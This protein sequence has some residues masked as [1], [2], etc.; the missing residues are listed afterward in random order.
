M[1]VK[2]KL[3]LG[4]FVFS[5]VG[6]TLGILLSIVTEVYYIGLFS[7]F[8]VFIMIGIAHYWDALYKK[9]KKTLN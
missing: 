3:L 7:L 1:S 4:L 2:H 5:F 8:T 6:F 9:E